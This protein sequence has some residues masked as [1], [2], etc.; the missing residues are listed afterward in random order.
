[1]KREVVFITLLASALISLNAA[2]MGGGMQNRASF[3]EFDLNGD[4]VITKNEFMHMRTYRQEKRAQEGYQMRNAANAPSFE[5]ID[6]NGD[7]KISSKEFLQFRQ[8]RMGKGMS[9][10]GGMHR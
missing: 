1:M 5:S 6:A 4:G 7:G 8:N 3:G 2:G 10:K 9:M